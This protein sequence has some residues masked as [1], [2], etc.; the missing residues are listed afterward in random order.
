MGKHVVD[1]TTRRRTRLSLVLPHPV[2]IFFVAATAEE[3]PRLVYQLAS[4]LLF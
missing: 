3:E 4:H 1:S 2:R